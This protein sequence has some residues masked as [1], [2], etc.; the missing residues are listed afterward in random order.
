MKEKIITGIFSISGLSILIG[1]I[2]FLSGITG[3]FIDINMQVSV[4]WVVFVVL[5][6][7]TL[8]LI[9]IKIIFDYSQHTIVPPAFEVPIKCI[10]NQNLIIIRKNDNFIN[11]I[12]VGCYSVI[13]GI[14][15]LAYLGFIHL[16]Q[17]KLIQIK[18]EVDYKVLIELPTSPD[19]LKNLVIRPVVPITALKEFIPMENQY[20]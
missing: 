7:G 14:D 2:G 8:L 3:L 17:D 10:K 4:K 18:V 6:T 15:Q 13:D 12:V 16:V 19:G 9:L 1:F 11:H 20:E 5:I